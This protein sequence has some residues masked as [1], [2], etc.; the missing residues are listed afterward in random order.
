[1]NTQIII[2]KNNFSILWEVQQRLHKRTTG[3]GLQRLAP[4]FL[5]CVYGGTLD[6]HLWSHDTKRSIQT[7]LQELLGRNPFLVDEAIEHL[8]RETAPN[9]IFYFPSILLEKRG[10]LRV[11]KPEKFKDSVVAGAVLRATYAL[12]VL[13][14]QP[15]HI[16]V[17]IPRVA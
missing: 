9:I 12:E 4:T 7:L 13:V 10:K 2:N 14:I 17:S 1:M 16:C 8:F 11:V 15:I 3:N 6:Q 5:A